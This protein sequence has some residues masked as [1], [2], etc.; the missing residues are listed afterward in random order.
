MQ[1]NQDTISN[2]LATDNASSASR[3]TFEISG[4]Q[5]AEHRSNTSLDFPL[6]MGVKLKK[7]SSREDR[8]SNRVFEVGAAYPN[9]AQDQVTLPITLKHKGQVSVTVRNTTGQVVDQQQTPSSKVPGEHRIQ[10]ELDHQS[11]GVYLYTVEVNG[12]QATGRLMLR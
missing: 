7:G 5:W 10:L 8:L 3:R 6:R 9:P 11:A 4:G 1:P 2:G 12:E